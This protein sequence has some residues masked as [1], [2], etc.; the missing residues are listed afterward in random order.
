MKQDINENLRFDCLT[1]AGQF[2]A[3]ITR[4]EVY[5]P[6][7]LDQVEA[8]MFQYMMKVLRRWRDNLLQ[9][10]LNGLEEKKDVN[11]NKE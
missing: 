4:L 3:V 10:G 5:E 6:K 9:Q 7:P 2:N 1:E 8:M 11:H